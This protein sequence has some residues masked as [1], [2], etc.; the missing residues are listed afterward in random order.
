MYISKPS[1]QTLNEI[2]FIDKVKITGRQ[3]EILGLVSQGLLN[4]QIADQLNISTNTVKAHLHELFRHLQ[5]T[6]RTS[7]VKYGMD[8]GLI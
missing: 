7:A 4:K 3:Q 6:N 2:E 1:N 5:V 8:N